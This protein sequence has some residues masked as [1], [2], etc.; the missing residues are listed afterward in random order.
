M[1]THGCHVVVQH[2]SAVTGGPGWHSALHPLWLLLVS[3]AALS[4]SFWKQRWWLGHLR[5]FPAMR[6]PQGRLPG[7][8]PWPVWDLSGMEHG[9]PLRW[10]CPTPAKTVLAPTPEFQKKFNYSHYHCEL[11]HAFDEK[12]GATTFLK[13]H[14]KYGKR[15]I[16]SEPWNCLTGIYVHF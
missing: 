14:V 4:G 15:S 5:M 2:G 7:H 3:P 12:T 8:V 10:L 11:G 16:A 9:L 1:R 13:D 6:R